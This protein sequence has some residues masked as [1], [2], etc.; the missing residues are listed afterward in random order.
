MTMLEVLDTAAEN[1]NFDVITSSGAKS[2][3]HSGTRLRTV[4]A[5][6]VPSHVS[7]AGACVKP[8]TER[9]A[10]RRS[11]QSNAKMEAET[12]QILLKKNS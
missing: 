8:P 4:L 5:I 2:S 12:C 1:E 11:A 3:F 7:H 10:G 6:R 9:R